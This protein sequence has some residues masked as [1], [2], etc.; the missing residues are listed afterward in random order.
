M[1]GKGGDRTSSEKRRWFT[2][3]EGSQFGNNENKNKK[4]DGAA[5][6]VRVGQRA[7]KDLLRTKV[8]GGEVRTAE[9]EASLGSGAQEGEEEGK[10]IGKVKMMRRAKGGK[11]SEKR[12]GQEETDEEDKSQEMEMKKKKKKCR[13]TLGEH[14]R[15][16][17]GA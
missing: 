2:S 9:E 12:K 15:Q 16:Q 7:E 17:R 1:P 10:G 14:Q 3:S 5:D 6:A 11:T 13:E 8:A 4:K